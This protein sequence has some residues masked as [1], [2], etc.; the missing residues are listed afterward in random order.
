MCSPHT[1][2]AKVF[3]ACVLRIH[4]HPPVYTRYKQNGDRL[5]KNAFFWTKTPQYHHGTFNVSLF[6]F[7]CLDST[8]SWLSITTN[9]AAHSE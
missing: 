7:T 9:S 2:C 1:M 8:D 5:M 4:V 3:S 6:L